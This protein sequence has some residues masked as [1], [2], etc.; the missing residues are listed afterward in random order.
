VEEQ[1]HRQD[2]D[3]ARR[4]VQGNEAAWRSLYDQSCQPLFNFLCYQV[5]N[6]EVARDLL[7]ETYL[8]GYESLSRYR[9]EGS[10]LSWL[11]TIA[12]RKSLDWKRVL[13]R[14]IR[15]LRVLAREP[16]DPITQPGD[17]RLDV[18]SATFRRT[19]AKLST[20]QRACLLLRELEELS[21]YEIATEIGCNE[22]TARVHYH[23]ARARM[24]TMLTEESAS[25]LADGMGGQQV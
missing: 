2:L 14:R 5:G 7:Q 11:R 15:H 23:R 19:L 16:R 21:F 17:A 1:A 4:A 25:A 3:L 12:L 8:T 9:G 20:R 10:L 6:R 13:V 18:E 24:K 22:A